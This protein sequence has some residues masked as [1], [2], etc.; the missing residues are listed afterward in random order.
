M[1]NRKDVK[2]AYDRL[3]AI[4]GFYWHLS[5]F[6]AVVTGL[7]VIN[8]LTLTDGDWWV[9]WVLFGWGIGVLAH[10]LAIFARKPRF[11][12][13]WEKRKLRELTRP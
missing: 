4:K 11:A 6:V 1:T 3:A 7:A 2:R 12:A 5:A 9:L 10:A 8:A 13:D